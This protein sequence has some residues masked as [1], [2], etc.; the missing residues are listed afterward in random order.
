MMKKTSNEHKKYFIFLNR[1]LPIR[2]FSQFFN[3]YNMVKFS[4]FFFYFWIYYISNFY[5][6]IYDKL[7]TNEYNIY[8]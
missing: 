2:T 3:F 1:Y 7:I 6:K 5:S 4:Q 8:K